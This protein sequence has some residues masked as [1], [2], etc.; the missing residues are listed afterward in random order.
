M[1]TRYCYAVEWPCGVATQANTGR[2]YRLVYRFTSPEDRAAW[3]DAGGDYRTGPHYREAVS[4]GEIE[5]EIRRA[6][7]LNPVGCPWM[8]YEDEPAA[9]ACV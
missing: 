9:E 7:T 2:P 5:S 3:V 1:K 8:R 6:A 4:R